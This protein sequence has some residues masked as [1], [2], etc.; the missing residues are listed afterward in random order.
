MAVLFVSDL[1]GTLFDGASRVSP[2]SL[3]IINGL[4][5]RGLRF[6]IATGRSPYTAIPLL[7]ELDLRLPVVFMNG[8]FVYDPVTEEYLATNVLDAATARRGIETLMA[9][10]LRPF[11][12]IVDESGAPRIHYQGAHNAAE[13]H[14]VDLR[15]SKGDQRFQLVDD[16]EA[17]LSQEILT[18]VTIDSEE[19]AA[20]A[21]EALAG[22]TGFCV[23]TTHDRDVLGN[24]WLELCH[25]L[26]NKGDAVRFVRDRVGATRLVCFG[27]NGNDLPM[28]AIAE[29]SYA[30]ANATEAALLA[31]S[32]VIAANHDDGVALHMHAAAAQLL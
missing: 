13:R 15:A 2:R 31:A 17:A 4:V 19:R 1:D 10:G 8:V 28:F 25:P 11:V 29:E 22:D 27:D 3:E 16:Y 21:R 7:R 12:F 26:A 5:A 14:F 6:T 20:A 9:Q 24:D 32:G 18:I 23:M 30:V